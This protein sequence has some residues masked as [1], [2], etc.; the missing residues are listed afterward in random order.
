[1][2]LRKTQKKFEKEV[3]DLCGK[4]YSVLGEYINCS[5]KITMKHVK[6]GNI[7]NVTPLSFYQMEE[8]VLNVL[9]WLEKKNLQLISRKKLNTENF[10]KVF[11]L[12][13]GEEYQI[14][15]EYKNRKTN[16][17]I[18][19]I[20]C[21]TEFY[22]SPSI[23]R[24]GYLCPNCSKLNIKLDEI[25]QRI[26]ACE[27]GDEYEIIGIPKNADAI[28][29]KHLICEKVYTT[30]LRS[31]EKLGNRCQFCSNR[32]NSK[33]IKKIR[34]WLIK[35]QII[36][37]EQFKDSRCKNKKELPFD[38]CIELEDNTFCLIEYDGEQHFSPRFGYNKS[39][40][41]ENL[42][43]YKINDQIKNKFC[44]KYKI[45]LIR[46]SFKEIGQINEKLTERFK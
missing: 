8:D 9:I 37:Q 4:E 16:I 29:L 38:F 10:K 27:N 26:A 41:I 44:K 36:F 6:C 23:I 21:G 45:E 33:G 11:Y 40:R 39:D 32:N 30:R 15:T 3:F 1:M 24:Q 5:T 42:K 19:H 35:E 22:K 14:L 34:D 2:S 43:K 28:Q 25:K 12:K 18:R 17:K 20:K 46:I 13:F 7:Y 31:F